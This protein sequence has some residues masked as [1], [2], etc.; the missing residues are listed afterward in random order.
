MCLGRQLLEGL[1]GAP[2]P[3]VLPEKDFGASQGYTVR[4]PTG[5]K[6][7]RLL[8]RVQE[9][10]P[11]AQM[12]QSQLRAPHTDGGGQQGGQRE[13]SRSGSQPWTAPSCWE[14][15]GRAMDMH[16]LVSPLVR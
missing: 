5:R 1:A 7:P 15:L 9:T 11:K 8:D 14:L 4:D 2:A 16:P 6:L 13:E 10:S 12:A 3:T